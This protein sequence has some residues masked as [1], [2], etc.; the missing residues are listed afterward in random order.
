MIEHMMWKRSLAALGACALLGL[1]ACSGSD[2]GDAK[3]DTSPTGSAATD[4]G[5]DSTDATDATDETD[6]GPS[7][8]VD[9]ADHGGWK[10][11]PDCNDFAESIVDGED[12]VDGEQVPGKS[13]RFTVGEDPVIGRQIVWIARHGGGWPTKFKAAALNEKMAEAADPGDTRYRSSVSEIDA[14]G[15]DYGTQFDEVVGKTERTSY[16]LF[17]FS[18]N[19]DL[20]SCHTSIGDAD[21][22][23]FRAWC[24]RVKDAV[25]P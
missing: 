14:R 8:T 10:V 2:D 20:L 22:K 1:T 21:L 19:G 9:P 4:R 25:T 11:L 13:C 17:A 12:L 6:G 7:T 5:S 23:A 18:E 3:D 15:W 24:D 16:R